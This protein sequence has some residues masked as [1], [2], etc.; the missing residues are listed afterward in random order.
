MDKMT[1]R[2]GRQPCS[3]ACLARR[4][5]LA[6]IGLGLF[7]PAKGRA[8]MLTQ[9]DTWFELRGAWRQR[10]ID[11]ETAFGDPAS[12]SGEGTAAG[13]FR[14]L[15]RGDSSVMN[16]MDKR[17]DG[18]TVDQGWRALCALHGWN[19]Q[20]LAALTRF[21]DFRPAEIAEH[22]AQA[23]AQNETGTQSETVARIQ[24]GVAHRFE[25]LRMV[26]F[27][28]VYPFAFSFAAAYF[29]PRLLEGADEARL[30]AL[31]PAGAAF[32]ARRIGMMRVK[33]YRR[34]IERWSLSED[35]DLAFWGRWAR[36]M[37]GAEMP[38]FIASL[39]AGAG[40]QRLF[41]G[42]AD[43]IVRAASRRSS[44]S[45]VDLRMLID[46][47]QS[48]RMAASYVLAFD[49][50]HI[51]LVDVYSPGPVQLAAVKTLADRIGVGVDL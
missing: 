51:P 32:V 49:Y 28:P 12:D 50:P 8:A 22:F 17:L 35:R 42:E 31:A 40:D 39:K 26:D 19:L 38:E 25:S 43:A 2:E 9:E 36:L 11:E 4:S 3:S 18:H 47:K 27:D 14:G 45:S 41:G 5:F 23:D 30:A 33:D 16:E 1:E 7:V 29:N 15:I 21:S 34:L 6:L 13:V 44:N 10:R 24:L 37:T 20:T 46:G 48:E